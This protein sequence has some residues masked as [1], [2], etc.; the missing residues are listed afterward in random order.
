M[1]KFLPFIIFLAAATNINAQSIIADYTFTNGS[2]VDV[3]GNNLNGILHGTLQSVA[4]QAGIPNT[5]AFFDSAQAYIAVPDQN[6]L[7]HITTWTILAKAKF[8]GFY[9]GLCQGNMIVEHSIQQDG[10]YFSLNVNDNIYD[11]NCNTFSPHNECASALAAGVESSAT[12]YPIYMDTSWHTII[13]TYDGDSV[14]VYIDSTIVGL[15]SWPNQYSYPGGVDTMYIG[16]GTKPAQYPNWFYGT[17]DRVMIFDGVI[18]DSSINSYSGHPDTSGVTTGISNIKNNNTVGFSFYPNPATTSI[19][20][21]LADNSK[22]LH[23]TIMNMYGQTIYSQALNGTKSSNVT[24]PIDNLATGS[25]LL[26][27]SDEQG[28]QTKQLTKL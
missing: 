5:A 15:Y 22:P 16:I 4:G 24:I 17:L 23:L 18:S 7:L 13:G 28:H 19:T 10:D 9:S 12:T 8:K 14:K 1:K 3:S 25:Y 6:N 26:D 11:N 20:V 2:A 21:S 27:I